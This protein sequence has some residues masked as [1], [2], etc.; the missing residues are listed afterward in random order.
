[1]RLLGWWGWW[2][3]SKCGR[4]APPCTDVF[5]LAHHTNLRAVAL[6][7]GVGWNVSVFEHKSFPVLV[8]VLV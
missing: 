3:G 8:L 4:D 7:D 6:S 2:N 1:M 5:A